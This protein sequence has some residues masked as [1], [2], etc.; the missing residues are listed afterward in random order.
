MND[1]IVYKHLFPNNKTYIGITCQNV[2][3]RWAGGYGYR[4]TLVGNAI[5]KYGWENV[6]HEILFEN[7]TKEEA[8]QKEIELIA[9]Y[10]SNQRKYGYNIANGGNHKGKVAEET[11]AKISKANKNHKVSIEARK[12]IS[13][14]AKTM[15]NNEEFRKNHLGKIIGAKNKPPWNKGIPQSERAKEINRAKHIG[16]PAWNKGIPMADNVKKAL[17][18]ANT[19][20]IPWNKGKKVN[21]IIDDKMR[22]KLIECNGKSKKVFCLETKKVYISARQCAI[23]L[24]LNRSGVNR[25]CVS[26]TH[27]YRGYHFIYIDNNKTECNVSNLIFG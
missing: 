7:L 25:A 21:R 20:R 18:K 17:I 15:W 22:K 9:Y 6:K 3:K 24:K 1:F 12:K 13:K 14:R 2:N 10:K 23:E 5:Q 11:K 19:G 16:K 8:E 26:S 27:L 4:N